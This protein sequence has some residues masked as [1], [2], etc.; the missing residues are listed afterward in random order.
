MTVEP[1]FFLTEMHLHQAA[2]SC[3][4]AHWSR[5]EFSAESHARDARASL[6]HALVP[7]APHGQQIDWL[8]ALIEQAISDSIDI[9]WEPAHGADAVIEALFAHLRAEAEKTEAA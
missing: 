5:D 9:D 7:D 6:A 8:H 4:L 3:L 2:R 1:Q